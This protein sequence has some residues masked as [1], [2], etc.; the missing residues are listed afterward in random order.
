MHC[1]LCYVFLSFDYEVYL[2]PSRVLLFNISD[3]NWY[4]LAESIKT[5]LG[6]CPQDSVPTSPTALK[7]GRYLYSSEFY[8]LSAPLEADTRQCKTYH[9]IGTASRRLGSSTH[10]RTTLSAVQHISRV[11][12]AYHELGS[13]CTVTYTGSSVRILEGVILSGSS[14]IHPCLSLTFFVRHHES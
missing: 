4:L 3:W 11:G 5:L 7:S 10:E 9:I 1:V 2:K 6:N 8:G 12:I 13:S 14:S